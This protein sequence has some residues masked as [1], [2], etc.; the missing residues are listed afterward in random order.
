MTV[1]VPSGTNATIGL[2]AAIPL[3]DAA[4]TWRNGGVFLLRRTPL[5]DA[6][7]TLDG[8]T[9]TVAKDLKAVVTRGP[10]LSSTYDETRSEALEAANN[11]LDYMCVRGLGDLAIRDDFDDCLMWWPDPTAGITIR[12]RAVYTTR[13][14][15]TAT[16]T[17]TDSS[18][19][20]VAPPPPAPITAAQHDAFRFIRMSRTSEYLFD[21]YRNMFL[22]LERLLSDIRPRAMHPN[23]KPAETE[24]AWFT[25][26]LQHADALAPVA[27]LAPAGEPNPIDWVYTNI[28]GAERSG[29]M[30]AKPGLYHLP[31]DDAGRAGLRASLR[32]LSGYVDE[33][34][35][36]VLNVRRNFS[37]F[38]T[39]GWRLFAEPF[40]DHMALIV[41]EE[42]L[43]RATWDDE[44]IE[45]VRR[46]YLNQV[47][48][49]TQ[50]I[51]EEPLLIT[52]LSVVDGPYLRSLHEIRTIAG[53][54]PLLGAELKVLSELTGPITVGS[55]VTRFEVVI[56][57]RNLNMPDLPNF[58]A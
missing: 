26:A 52:G 35:G 1:S 32:V 48:S 28:Y 18:G 4:N 22:A 9:T 47:R 12:A 57:L 40:F 33:L 20:T 37:G 29:L 27:T 44:T 49:G 36:V 31:Q 23:G 25:A 50:T 56:G 21:S 6:E 30:H 5:I 58:S 42:E 41:A 24:K 16:G 19:N 53:V 34:A 11:G 54:G 17:V 45:T 51:V 2:Y 10:S 3:Q 7:A 14:T 39:A 55:S 13:V 43:P 46:K 15:F 38:S 8:W